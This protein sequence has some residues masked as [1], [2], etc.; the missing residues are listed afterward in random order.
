MPAH[1]K[2]CNCTGTPATT[3]QDE[4]YGKG[5]RVF[6]EKKEGKAFKCTCCG[7]IINK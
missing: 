5:M 1:V 7:K 3:F 2:P 4:N 6:S